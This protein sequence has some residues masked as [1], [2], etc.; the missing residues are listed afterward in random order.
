M[1]PLVDVIVYPNPSAVGIN[2]VGRRVHC[3]A[4]EDPFNDRCL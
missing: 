3:P 1:Y 4:Q 2:K